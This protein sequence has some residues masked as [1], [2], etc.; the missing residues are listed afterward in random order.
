MGRKD[1]AL[2]LQKD[3]VERDQGLHADQQFNLGLFQ[4]SRDENEAALAAFNASVSL[5]PFLFRGWYYLAMVQERLGDPDRAAEAYR[6]CLA[7]S[8][9]FTRG[10]LSLCSLL[11]GS[12]QRKEARRYLLHGM[13]VADRPEEMKKAFDSLIGPEQ[14]HF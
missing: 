2:A 6:R 11:V 5:N 14:R 3:L 8:P 9:S 4:L 13:R 7:I 1:E 10:Y 12:G